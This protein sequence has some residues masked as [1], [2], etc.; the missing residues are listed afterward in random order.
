MRSA[1]PQGRPSAVGNSCIVQQIWWSMSIWSSML[2]PWQA[3]PFMHMFS[4]VAVLLFCWCHYG[5]EDWLTFNT[6]FDPRILKC[7]GF[8]LWLLNSKLVVSEGFWFAI[9]LAWNSPHVLGMIVKHSMPV[10]SIDILSSILVVRETDVLA[11]C[12]S[13]LSFLTWVKIQVRVRIHWRPSVTGLTKR[14]VSE[15]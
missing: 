5:V 11:I 10:R 6:P 13:N 2:L 14:A 4:E 7:C 12:N 1:Y 15:R 8:L 9:I 3:L